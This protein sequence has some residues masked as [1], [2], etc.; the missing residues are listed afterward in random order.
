MEKQGNVVI[1]YDRYSENWIDDI[2]DRMEKHL[3]RDDGYQLKVIPIEAERYSEAIEYENELLNENVVVTA[4]LIGTRDCQE[5]KK[6]EEVLPYINKLV[7]HAKET[8]TR[9]VLM[10]SL[11][12]GG[13]KCKAYI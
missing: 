10:T 8:N 12:W 6:F 13:A 5:G 1:C 2:K 7:L 4:L 3:K 9:L 11:S